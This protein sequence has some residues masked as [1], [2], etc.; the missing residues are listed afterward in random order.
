MSRRKN[1]QPVKMVITDLRFTATDFMSRKYRKLLIVLGLMPAILLTS[2]SAQPTQGST[3]EPA[4]KLASPKTGPTVRTESGI[5]HGVTE[6][7]VS[8]FKGIPYAAPPVGALRWRP[9]QPLPPWEG[10]RDA[11]KFGNPLTDDGNA[12][13]ASTGQ[14]FAP[15]LL[16]ISGQC[17]RKS[18]V[19]L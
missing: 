7:D 16:N 10:E 11:S 12:H 4:P 19:P 15:V 6:G 5:V 3:P 18:C 9:P 17:Q 13:N 8:S 2:A 14:R 1:V